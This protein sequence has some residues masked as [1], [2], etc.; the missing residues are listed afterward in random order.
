MKK[1]SKLKKILTISFSILGVI[2]VLPLAFVGIVTLSMN[3][4]SLEIDR[5]EK[6]ENDT[7]LVQQR[8]KALYD[9]DGNYLLLRG[10]N[11]GNLLVS[12]GW[13]SPYSVGEKLDDDG[14][15]ALDGDGLP[16]YPELPME[17]TVTGF[18]S[19]PNLTDAQREELIGIYRANWFS[20]SDFSFIKNDLGMN[21][22][23]LPFY[24][25]DILDESNGVFDRKNEEEAF[26]YIDWFLE[27]CQ[28]NDLYCILDLHGAPG[29]Q[30]GYEHCGDMTK[31]DLW[32]NKTYQDATVD[33]WRFVS[34]HYSN[35]RKDLAPTIA[36][37]DL[38]NEPCAYYDN[39]NAGTSVDVCYPIFDKIYDAI[40]EMGDNHV[41]CIEGV[42]SFDCFDDP[43]N[44]GWDNVLYQTHMYNWNSSSVP[45]WLFN[46]YHELHNWGHDYDVPY[47]I[48]EF[49][50][51]EDDAA[52]QSQLAM[53]EKRGY[54]WSMWTY[55]ASVTGWWTTSWS[56]YTQ[57][58]NLSDGKT[59]VN[60]KTATYDEL[61]K[62]FESTNTSNCELSMTYGYIKKFMES[63]K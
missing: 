24:W 14:S 44:W 40:R 47:Y 1:K 55:K 50:F 9:K 27:Q 10:V 2:I 19:N 28:R 15:I 29:S 34:E 16:T 32:T 38:M 21:M 17:E 31:A 22:V 35:N 63:Q 46:D 6:I 51:F 30:N 26:E 41:I 8:G 20:E 49:T 54:S 45:Y 37:Y 56:I 12:E 61:K 3:N 62:A 5:T 4:R 58:L 33:L 13:I 52:W 60:L 43:S 48:G 23:R 11:A 53:Y 7:G 18:E 25:R 36:S 39:Q 57:Q 42:W 59:K